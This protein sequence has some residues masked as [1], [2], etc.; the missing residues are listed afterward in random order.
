M[1][2]KFNY[3]ERPKD[4]ESCISLLDKAI[5]PLL[6][7][8]WDKHG[9]QFFNKPFIMNVGAF[10]AHWMERGLVM[11]IAYDGDEPV[12]ILTGLRFTPM[13]FATRILQIDTCYGKTADVEKGLYN[14][15]KELGPV[16]E[17][18]EFWVS[19]DTCRPEHV[20]MKE[21]A[22]YEMVRFVRE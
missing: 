13:N 20:S 1:A 22:R 12:G 7:E 11:V 5:M 3:I 9:K 6:I 17:Y 21:I 15:I 10:V 16:L 4:V 14:Y 8:S 18:D 19:T 2:L